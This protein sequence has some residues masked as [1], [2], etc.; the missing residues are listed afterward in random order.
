MSLNCQA[1]FFLI[2]ILNKNRSHINSISDTYLCRNAV[3]LFERLFIIGDRRQKH[4]AYSWY[5]III[6]TLRL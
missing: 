4:T 2:R 5:I 3:H 1:N 6:I